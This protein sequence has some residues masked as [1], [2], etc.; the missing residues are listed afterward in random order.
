MSNH[1]F[2]TAFRQILVTV[3][4]VFDDTHHL[5]N[6]FPVTVFLFTCSLQFFRI[7]IKTFNT[8]FFGPCKSFFVFCMIIDSFC[9]TTDNFYLING[10]Y[11]HAKIFFKEFRADDRSADTHTDRS[12]LQVGFSSHSSTCNG[13]TSESQ[14]FFFYVCRD[15]CVICILYVCSVNTECRKTFLSMCCQNRCQINSSWSFCTIESPYSFDSIWI[16]IHGFCTVAPAWCNSQCNINACFFEFVCTCSSF[17]NT[18]D[19]CVSDYNFYRFTVAVSQIVCKQFCCG[20]CHV[21]GL[22]FQRLT[23][24]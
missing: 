18:S 9:H 17:C 8:F 2:F 6:E 11:T 19:G 22:L 13:C 20:F 23:Y 10:L 7:L 4:Q 16:H 21:H 14:Q 1:L 15:R 5:N 3:H 24:F 12:N